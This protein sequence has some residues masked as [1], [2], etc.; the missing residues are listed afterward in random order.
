[1]V[2]LSTIQV[3]VT[4]V[5]GVISIGWVQLIFTSASL[6]LPNSE[7][8]RDRLAFAH[9]VCQSSSLC[10]LRLRFRILFHIIY[11]YALVLPLVSYLWTIDEFLFREYRSI[12]ISKPLVTISVPRGGTTSFH[13]TLALDER[14]ATPRMLELV[15]PFLCLHKIV[16][17]VQRTF[18]MFIKHLELF[19]KWINGVTPVVEARH[20][21][22]LL[23]PDA[24]DI[25]VGEWHWIGVGA[26]RTAPLAEFWQKHSKIDALQRAGVARSLE[27][28]QRMCQKVLHNHRNSDGSFRRLLLRSHLSS[29]IS[30]FQRLYPDATLV[31]ILREPVEVLQSFAGLTQE[32][33]LATSG[34]D[35]L[36]EGAS[37][38]WPQLFVNILDDMMATE[39]ALYCK[40]VGDK[41]TAWDGN[42]HYVTFPA[43]RSNP[44]QALQRLFAKIEL[45]MTAQMERAI[46]QGLRDHET[47]KPRHTYKNPTLEEMGISVDEFLKLSGVKAYKSLLWN[48]V[49]E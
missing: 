46:E 15:L 26:A 5:V 24:D 18:P 12:Q 14:F 39:S 10:E 37:S 8:A 43:F 38:P 30:D 16:Y 2:D 49:K 25:L 6:L 9:G 23:A 47:Y 19:L 35:L 28:H 32:V 41:K 7:A 34:I 29:C 22:S 3:W 20:P 42:C 4:V 45:P 11:T 48:N 31:G 36:A 44:G 21:V 13:R 40:K 17:S 27:L 33:I 1:M